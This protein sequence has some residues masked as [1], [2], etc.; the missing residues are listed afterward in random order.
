MLKSQTHS[1]QTFLLS[2][3]VGDVHYL[4]LRGV[5]AQPGESS[6]QITGEY[7][8]LPQPRLQGLED[9]R[10]VVQLLPGELVRVVGNVAVDLHL[11]GQGDVVEDEG[12]VLCLEIFSHGVMS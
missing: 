3:V 4:L 6:V 10:H 11:C 5:E 7:R 1:V 9:C 8:A 12:L 2:N